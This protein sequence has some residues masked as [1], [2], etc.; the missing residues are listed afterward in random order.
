MFEDIKFDPDN[1][2]LCELAFDTIVCQLPYATVKQLQTTDASSNLLWN[3]CFRLHIVAVSNRQTQTESDCEVT[4]H[5]DQM[6]R[7]STANFKLET[8]VLTYDNKPD[9][10]LP[11]AKND[12]DESPGPIANENQS[13]SLEQCLMLGQNHPNPS[14]SKEEKQAHQPRLDTSQQ[15]SPNGF[16]LL[17]ELK[18]SLEHY[19]LG[20]TF[21]LEDPMMID[22]DNLDFLVT[23]HLLR[24]ISSALICANRAYESLK[25]HSSIVWLS[26][27]RTDH[28]LYLKEVNELLGLPATR[29]SDPEYDWNLQVPLTHHRMS[30]KPYQRMLKSCR[31]SLTSLCISSLLPQILER[32]PQGLDSCHKQLQ[33]Y[34]YTVYLELCQRVF[35]HECITDKLLKLLANHS[36]TNEVQR[37]LSIL[38]SSHLYPKP[39]Q[40]TP[41]S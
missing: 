29:Y 36:D 35:N 40:A 28:S 24:D 33:A 37:T 12:N 11:N 30:N 19:S 34:A 7:A 38:R 15:D 31:T 23:S 5:T 25:L 41:T 9:T 8:A 4:P 27:K 2:L 17:T 3:R 22:I 14:P 21:T 16:N 39:S 6:S 26:F 20:R 18:T 32:R 10:A 1:C 13:S